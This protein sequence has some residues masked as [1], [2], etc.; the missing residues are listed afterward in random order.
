VRLASVNSIHIVT[1]PVRPE[2]MF[3]NVKLSRPPEK[4][5]HELEGIFQAFSLQDN[6]FYH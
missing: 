1:W 2:C 6:G 4:L 5:H 3:Y